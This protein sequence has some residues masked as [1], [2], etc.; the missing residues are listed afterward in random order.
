MF[1]LLGILWASW[2]QYL[3][4]NNSRKKREKGNNSRNP[5]AK[6]HNFADWK[7]PPS[8]QHNGRRKTHKATSSWN[9]RSLGTG[10]PHKSFQRCVGKPSSCEKSGEWGRRL[11]SRSPRGG[12]EMGA[13]PEN[14]QEEKGCQPEP[15]THTALSPN[16]G[17]SMDIYTKASGLLAQESTGSCTPPKW[18][19]QGR[20]HGGHPQND[21]EG[22]SQDHR[23]GQM[24]TPIE[25]AQG[26]CSEAGGNRLSGVYGRTKTQVW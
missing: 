16:G 24:Q 1:S 2:I 23:A 15:W 19:K 22:R 11:A 13:E 10:R 21:G 12:W 14:T 18:V 4:S 3:T 17:G 7:G 9:V 25:R 5:E 6:W 8:S 20:G 26:W